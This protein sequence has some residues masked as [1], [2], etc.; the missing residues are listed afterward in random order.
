MLLAQILAQRSFFGGEPC[1]YQKAETPMTNR[2]IDMR[3]IRDV[4]TYIFDRR[5]SN[6][7]TAT[8]FGTNHSTIAK[9]LTRFNEAGL[10]W[11]LPEEMDDASL[12][13]LLFQKPVSVVPSKPANQLIDFAEI[14]EELKKK[15]ATLAALHT[16]WLEQAPPKDA[17]SY[18]QFCRAYKAFKNSLR[19]SARQTEV[20]GTNTYVDYS[21]KTIDIT[22][23]H[24]GEVRVAQIFVGVLGGSGYAYCEATWTQRSRDWLGA[25]TRMFAYFGGVSLIVVPDN[26]KAAVTKA[27]RLFPVINE[28]YKA[29]C[30][31]Y[32]IAPFPAR[33]YSPTDKARA[34][35][36]VFLVQ[37]WI[38]FRLRKRKFFT[39]E[40]AN[41]EIRLLLEQLNLKPFQKLKGCRQSRWLEHEL[42]TLQPL[43]MTPYE[44]AEWGK[45]RAGIDYHVNI[46]G[47][48]YSVP[49]QLR[50][51]EFDYR[52]TDKN[53]ELISKG[54]SIAAHQR[55]YRSEATT[56]LAA[57]RH[58]AHQAV[59]GW[60]EVAALAWAATVGPSTKAVLEIKLSHTHG[61]T[62]GYR[63]TQTMKS[64][65]KAHGTNR[66][67]EAC[68]YAL[69]HK[70][71]KVADL[72]S[73][74]DKR[75]DKLL[76]QDTPE[77]ASP[78]VS[79]QNIR[80]ADYYD[81]ILKT[82]QESQS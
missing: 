49:Y 14:H 2:R 19:I 57:H 75:L 59:Q 46:D 65:A 38:L 82:N 51:Q 48:N 53:V 21:G 45:V 30:R 11:P 27:D 39:L 74:L 73:I 25:H 13:N 34:E 63:M 35:S 47:H 1:C 7:K 3:K 22:D 43:P 37:R 61:E 80:G 33:G 68:T 15:G 32:R 71:S 42:P 24:T 8:I 60:S 4:L 54:R 44:F 52:L 29:M 78:E 36:G 17:L 10:S 50:G 81:R 58:P 31:H 70:I 69:A 28:S 72:R 79:H 9:Y 6:R 76:S 26:L 23:K 20:Y 56:T 66:L 40:E 12:E 18:S 55:S 64:L 5:F 62:M 16:E 41:Q 77:V 67:E